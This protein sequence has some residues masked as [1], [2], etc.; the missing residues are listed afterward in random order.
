M[1]PL[2]EAP[3]AIEF[4]RFRV[5]PRQR[6]LM[7]DDRPVEL[8]GRAFDL[9]MALIEAQGAVVSKQA[10]IERVWPGRIVEEA[11]LLIQMSVLRKVLAPDSRLIRTVAG[12]GY[13]ITG[14]IRAVS[15]S[16][17]QRA[18]MAVPEPLPPVSQS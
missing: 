1:H 8:G 4:G 18:V 12:Q 3:A 7:A 11:N 13:Q 9:L 16:G 5:L 2:S 15:G 6:K 10:L 17:D 14:E